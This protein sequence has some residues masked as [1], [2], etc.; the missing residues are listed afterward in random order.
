MTD[1]L[2]HGDL[3]RVWHDDEWRDGTFQRLAHHRHDLAW[4][5]LPGHGNVTD[6][7][8]VPI[9]YVILKEPSP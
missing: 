3:I 9:A 4:V 8:L 7:F 2:T 6:L 5:Y 1:H